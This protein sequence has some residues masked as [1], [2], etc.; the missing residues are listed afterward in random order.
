[1]NAEPV[2]LFAVAT[3]PR[4]QRTNDAA[5]ANPATLQ[6]PPTLD[7]VT[8]GRLLG[9]GRTVAYRLVRSG[10]WPTPTIRVGRKIKIPTAPLLKF[11]GLLHEPDLSTVL[12]TT[13]TD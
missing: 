13:S 10:E 3:H 1:M 9:I 12:A 11:L 8:A 4:Q 7:V 5:A 6:L 2:E